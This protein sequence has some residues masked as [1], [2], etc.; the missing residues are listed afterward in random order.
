M[1]KIVMEEGF[2]TPCQVRGRGNERIDLLNLLFMDY[3]LTFHKASKDE[4][5]H[6][7]WLLKWFEAILGLK[8]NLEKSELSLVGMGDD[9]K[10]FAIGIR[11]KFNSLPFTCFGLNLGVSFK[12]VATWDGIEERFQR[13]LAMWK[14]LHIS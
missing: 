14:R 8:I 7:F 3:I 6:L 9:L 1:F 13:R 4:T 11:F 10:E 2:L 12:L 5:T